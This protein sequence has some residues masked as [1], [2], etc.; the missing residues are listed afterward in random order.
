[1]IVVV[2]AKGGEK[3]AIPNALLNVPSAETMTSVRNGASVIVSL[4]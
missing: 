4:P 2:A 3:A 1:M